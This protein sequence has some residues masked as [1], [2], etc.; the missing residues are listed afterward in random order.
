MGEET[1]P[2]G[3]KEGGDGREAAIQEISD[4]VIAGALCQRR[5]NMGP[6]RRRNLGPLAT[7]SLS[8]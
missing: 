2:G 6:L 1:P 8:L 3:G 7:A 4:W 5:S